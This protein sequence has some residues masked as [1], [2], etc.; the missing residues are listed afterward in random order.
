MTTLAFSDNNDSYLNELISNV[1]SST[2]SVEMIKSNFNNIFSNV[3][4]KMRESDKEY[5]YT[6]AEKFYKEVDNIPDYTELYS[7]VVDLDPDSAT[8]STSTDA[9]ALMELCTEHRET[10]TEYLEIQ[11]AMIELYQFY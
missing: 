4:D 6:L 10:Y 11:D 3:Y 1:I 2:K 9:V 5:I 7:I 8:I